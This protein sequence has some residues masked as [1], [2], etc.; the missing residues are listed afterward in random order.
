MWYA[1]GA[2]LG[3]G[4]QDRQASYPQGAD[5]QVWKSK[6]VVIISVLGAVVLWVGEAGGS[7]S[8]RR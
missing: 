6:Q 3:A 7:G 2:G 4:I 8:T 1:P 5:R